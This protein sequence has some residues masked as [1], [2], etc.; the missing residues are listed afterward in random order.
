MEKR[1]E[2]LLM[3]LENEGQTLAHY[4]MELNQMINSGNRIDCPVLMK[5]CQ[6][7]NEHIDLFDKID[8]ELSNYENIRLNHPK[9]NASG[10]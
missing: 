4:R 1:E 10:I 8:A 9:L 6:H 3:Q 5:I 2:L 7:I